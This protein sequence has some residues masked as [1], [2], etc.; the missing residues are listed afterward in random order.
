IDPQNKNQY[1][2]GVQYPEKD[3]ETMESL[4]NVRITSPTQDDPIPLSNVVSL[5]EQK[6][7]AEIT[8][9]NLASTIDLTMNVEG[10]DLGHVADDVARLLNDFGEAAGTGAWAPYA[11]D[12]S[13]SDEDRQPLE[14]YKIT[15]SGEY[16]KMQDT[17]RNLAVG[18]ILAAVLIYFLM[19]A[20][21]KSYITP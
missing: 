13:P 5:V 6:T 10:R 21:F 11:P 8:H 2:V 16:A 1:F 20:L 14:G 9:S 3:L 7:A 18:L 19:T 12:S 4:L 15:L 17:F